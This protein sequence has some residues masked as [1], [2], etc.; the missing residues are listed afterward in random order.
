MADPAD[1]E[2]VAAKQGEW[3]GKPRCKGYSQRQNLEDVRLKKEINNSDAEISSLSSGI[4][5]TVQINF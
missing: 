3:W 4:V 5:D 1:Q 2:A